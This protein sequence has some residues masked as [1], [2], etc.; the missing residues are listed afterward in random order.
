MYIGRFLASK[1]V[2]AK[3]CPKIPMQ[4][5]CKP[6]I[7]VIIQTRD[8]HP[9]TG[10][11]KISVRTTIRQIIMNEKKQKHT[12]LKDAMAKGLVENAIIPSKEYMKSFQ[13]RPFCF[14]CHTLN[15]YI[16]YPFCLKTYPAKY[17]FGK[18][19]VLI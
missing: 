5:N 4:N 17:S 16:L 2:F 19:I 9:E 10:S 12:P 11:P 6:P 14:P 15:I 8:G 3:Y 18:S 7:A 1:Y 13:E